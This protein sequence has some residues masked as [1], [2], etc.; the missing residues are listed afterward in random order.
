VSA[1]TRLRLRVAPGASRPGVVGRHG[2]A[3]K[4]RVAAAPVEGMANDAL[5]RLLADILQLPVRDIEIVSGHSSRD[6]IVEL[7]GIDRGEI[8][9]AEIERRLAEA[10]APGKDSA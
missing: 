8:D 1:S 7:A 5:V 3:W 10:S 2:S 4:V 6:K 9:L